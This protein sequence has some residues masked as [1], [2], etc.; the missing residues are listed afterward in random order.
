MITADSVSINGLKYYKNKILWKYQH[1][2]KTNDQHKD[3]KR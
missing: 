2:D 1:K 3:K